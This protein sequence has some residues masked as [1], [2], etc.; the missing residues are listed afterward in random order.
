MGKESSS[1][2]DR[3]QEVV[4]HYADNGRSGMNSTETIK[5]ILSVL[6]RYDRSTD[7]QEE[8][9]NAIVTIR[10]EAERVDCY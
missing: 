6:D 2:A 3:F 9:V 5:E 4:T 8:Q 1:V 7:D 10:R